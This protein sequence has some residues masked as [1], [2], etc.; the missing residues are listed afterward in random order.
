MEKKNKIIISL[1]IGGIVIL[2]ACIFGL[3]SCQKSEKY[4]VTFIDSIDNKEISSV[5][6]EKNKKVERP[7][8]P[9]KDGYTFDNWYYNDA[10]YDFNTKVVKNMTIE[11]RFNQTGNDNIELNEVALGMI[12]DETKLLEILNLPDGIQKNDLVW[13]SSDIDIVTVDKDGNLKAIKDGTVTITVKT[14]D[15]KYE[16]TCKVTVTKEEVEVKGISIV[17][18]STLTV[19]SNIKLTVTFNPDNATN[20]NLKW[21]S[22]N[23]SIAT[24][25]GNGNVKGLKEGKVTIKAT[26]ENGKTATK[27][28]TVT[29][30]STSQNSNNNNNSSNNNNNN[31]S[32]PEEVY[33][34]NV[35]ITG[36]D[37]VN[38]GKTIQL[39]ATVTPSNATNTSVTWSSNNTGIA[40]VN[41]SGVVTGE[42]DGEVI[43]TATTSN[44]KTATYKVTVKSDYVITFTGIKQ[45]VTGSVMQYSFTVTK[46]GSNLDNLKAISFTAVKSGTLRTV[47]KGQ[48]L[49]VEDI[50]YEDIKLTTATIILTDNSK[51]TNNITL[52]YK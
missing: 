3:R 9:K 30:K 38:V 23:T 20:Q 39:T 16:A 33:P 44:G 50:L 15:G 12:V 29:A 22:S 41:Q 2:L 32:K 28:I 45:D 25:D 43:I 37:V 6:V 36:L 5:S 27:T 18:T 42:D 8:D 52:V 46:N 51:V 48:K 34:D 49:A 14:K 10:I 47:S 35:T 1:M 24:V 13:E 7:K 4:E 31:P 26:T 19:G 17:G 40:T 11:A 21:E